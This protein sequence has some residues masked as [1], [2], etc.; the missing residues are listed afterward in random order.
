[1]G[2]AD[3]GYTGAF[4]HPRELVLSNMAEIPFL[5]EN[6]D[7]QIKAHHEIYTSGGIMQEEFHQNGVHALLFTTIG[8]AI[9]GSKEPIETVDDL[10]GLSIRATGRI[11]EVFEMVGAN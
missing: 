11:A 3:L 10:R 1:D 6:V 7:A 8:S 4:Y 9:I 5:T 2:R